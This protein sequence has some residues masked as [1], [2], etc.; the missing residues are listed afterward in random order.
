MTCRALN[1]AGY[2]LATHLHVAHHPT[3]ADFGQSICKNVFKYINLKTFI[4]SA[5]LPRSVGLQMNEWLA[6]FYS[7]PSLSLVDVDPYTAAVAICNPRSK[8]KK[9]ELHLGG[10]LFLTGVLVYALLSLKLLENLTLSFT[11]DIG[12]SFIS[13]MLFDLI[14][15]SNIYKA[16]NYAK[17]P[18]SPRTCNNLF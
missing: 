5:N 1:E 16:S 6:Q 3:L 13:D 9:I 18:Y 14:I 8:L 4:W 17:K 2:L 12:H 7:P 11:T 15:S 10:R